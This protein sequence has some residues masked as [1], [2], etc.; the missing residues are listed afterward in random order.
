MN[1]S[2]IQHD[3]QN[4][5]VYIEELKNI[6]DHN[7]HSTYRHNSTIENHCKIIKIY[8]TVAYH[9]CEKYIREYKDI[10]STHINVWPL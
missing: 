9:F 7:I 2:D 10:Y 8:V 5:Q 4:L 6:G 1:R 3:K